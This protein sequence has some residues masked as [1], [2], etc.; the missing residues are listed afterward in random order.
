MPLRL[1]LFVIRRPLLPALA[2]A[3]LLLL[4]CAAAPAAP[5]LP[6]SDD[7]V[8]ETLPVRPADPRMAEVNALRQA[9]RR[10]PGDA[11]TAVALARHYYELVAAE[12]DPRYV[13]Y[14]QAALAPWWNLPQPPQRV[15]VMRA[16]LQQFNH[17]FK[18][19]LADLTAAV[20]ADPGDA[21]A[22]SWLAAIHMVQ[23]DYAQART[24]CER[25]APYTSALLA[26]ACS[27]TVDSVTG[28][29]EAAAKAIRIA[30]REQPQ[31]SAPERLW[32]LTRLG[33][34]EERRGAFEAA[35]AAYRAGLALD[36]T[37]GYLLAAYADFLLD[38]GR[39]QEVL[40]LLKDKSRSDVLLLRLAL[41]AKAAKAPSLA[42]YER[43]MGSRFEAARLRGDA[44]HEKEE[45]R[46]ALQVQGQP[47]RALQLAQNNYA[48]Q[49]EPADARILLEAA[50][51]AR[52]PAA[53]APVLQW[54]AESHI[55]SVVLQQLAARLKEA[56]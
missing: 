28:R 34:I 40:T 15:R 49:R 16:V 43:D 12:G 23:A 39:P 41:A 9:L 26:T 1:P 46:F 13:G 17:R 32:V 37:D 3:P 51:A 38:R 53:A 18:E 55:E 20:Q 25:V 56:R 21:E 36:L 33:E 14:A 4:M 24:A 2:F 8:L 44:T 45:A 22:W 27:A 54:M 35:E 5:Y 31:A 30:L 7:Q 48:V 19:A 52:Q 10:Q 42:A 50:I 47:A 6:R 29:A 11:G